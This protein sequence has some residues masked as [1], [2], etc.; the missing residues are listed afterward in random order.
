MRID[1]TERYLIMVTAQNNNKFYRMIP[2]FAS[3]TFKAIWGR[4]G[5]NGASCTYPISQ[6]DVKYAEKINKGYVDQTDIFLDNTPVT[7]TKTAET[8]ERELTVAERLIIM[9]KKAAGRFMRTNYTI[10]AKHV[11]RAMIQKASVLIDEMHALICDPS[12]TVE[13][14]NGMLMTLFMTIPRAMDNTRYHI[15]HSKA[16]FGRILEREASYLD[17]LRGIVGM[18]SNTNS[19][20]GSEKASAEK[21]I[22]RY[23]LEVWDATDEQVNEVKR[24]MGS[25]KD[26]IRH[27]WRVENGGT[28]KKFDEYVKKRGIRN[29][30]KLFHGSRTENFLSIISNGLLLD[31]KA[32][33][34]GKMFG[35]GIYFAPSA[36][37]SIG[38]TSVYGSY[39][40]SGKSSKGYLAVYD[41]AVGKPLDVHSYG[42]YSSFTEKDMKAN[43]TDSLFAHKGTML[44]NDE[45]IVYNESAAT[46][47]YL[48]EI[49]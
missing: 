41:V 30:K 33:I 24:L 35:Y 49:E 32:V 29:V 20:D 19:D 31:P 12:T 13:T 48:V 27:V 10:S 16:D 4:V 47:R 17:S 9:L 3:G 26:R 1:N 15:A 36:Q 21:I 39:W 18:Y 45:V 40:A 38:Y 11:T 46:I 14:F 7:Q 28:R 8:D 42:S 5:Q 37:K 43:G 2:D 23:G 6:W 34:T 25:S 22:S 44:R